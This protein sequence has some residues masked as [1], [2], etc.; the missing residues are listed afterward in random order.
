MMHDDLTTNDLRRLAL[1][2]GMS[3]YGT[4][5]ELLW[6]LKDTPQRELTMPTGYRVVLDSG[7]TVDVVLTA[8]PMRA[9]RTAFVQAKVEV[10]SETPPLTI[11]E[12]GRTIQDA[13]FKLRA[14]IAAEL[15]YIEFV[16][17]YHSTRAEIVAAFPCV[18]E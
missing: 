6:R 4:R 1:V 5:A 15:G 7:K 2:S 3:A 12:T 18:A 14:R 10:P 8:E 17:P 11:T 16:S 13:L 9:L